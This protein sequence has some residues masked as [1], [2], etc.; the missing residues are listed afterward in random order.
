MSEPRIHHRLV[1]GDEADR[2]L[3]VLH[4][5]Y[6]AG[7]NWASLAKALTAYRP[8]W[9]AVLVDLRLH[10][11]SQ[12]FSPPHTLQ[13]CVADL[14]ALAAGEGRPPAAVLGH[15]FGGKVA[16]LWAARGAP[17]Q[18]WVIDSTPAR[19]SPGG[20]AYRMLGI[21]ERLPPAFASRAEAVAALEAAG[22]AS[23]VAQWMATNLVPRGGAYRWR[24]DLAGIASL[25]DDFFRV[26]L[27]DV[28]EAPPAG[29]EV[30]IV[31]ADQSD[32]LDEADLARVRGAARDTSGADAGGWTFLHELHGGHWLH[33]DNPDGLQALLVEH[34]D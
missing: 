23:H 14:A 16:L 22:F 15:S 1:G 19:R 9:G 4:G 28:V 31:R 10:G 27:W 33:V 18:T 32:V 12:G 34:L 26:D 20:S 13:A 3:Y 24:F 11:H 17:R 7:R 2:W 5:I 30:H 25:L 8:E 6:G 21:L 29:A